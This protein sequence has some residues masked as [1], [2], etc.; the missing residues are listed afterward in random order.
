MAKGKILAI[1]DERYFRGFYRVLLE[2][3]GYHIVTADSGKG[4]LEYLYREEFDLVILD[5]ELEG[6]NVLEIVD[7]VKCLNPE[8]EILAVTG[9]NDVGLAVRA[10]KK[11]TSEYLLKPI[12]PEAFLLLLGKILFRQSVRREH[13]KLLDENIDYFYMVASL[14]KC[15]ELLKINDIDR[16]SDHIADLMMEMLRADGACLWLYREMARHFR[17][18]SVRGLAKVPAEEMVFPLG[19]GERKKFLDGG[20]F[21]AEARTVMVPIN[22]AG[23]TIAL[24]RIEEPSGRERFSRKDFKLAEMVAEFA[25]CGLHNALLLRSLE[26]NVLRAPSGEFYNMA[27]FRDHVSKEIL[28]S[29]RYR[30]NLSILKLKIENYQDLMGNFSDKE[31]EET[32]R[33]MADAVNT[34]LREADIMAMDQPDEYFI[35]LP[36]TDFW[37]ALLTQRRILRLLRPS[38][39]SPVQVGKICTPLVRV[40]AATFPS[41]GATFHQLSEVAEHRLRQIENSLPVRIGIEDVPFWTAMEHVLC[42]AG[43]DKIMASMPEAGGESC[44]FPV[45]GETIETTMRS[46]CLELVESKR[47]RGFIYRGCDGFAS[48]LEGFSLVEGIEKSATSVYLLGGNR[49]EEWDYQRIIPLHISDP[50]FARFPFFFYLSEEFAYAL[51]THRQDENGEWL[52]FHSSDFYFVENMILKLQEQ[53]RLQEQM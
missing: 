28:K 42:A 35:L 17:L 38:A 3:E 26:Q 34:T 22:Y 43:R 7:A 9:R 13:G 37:G 1:D 10:M 11:G 4:G 32:L 33:R 30:R 46:F 19:E 49:R 25:A 16:L 45:T 31:V 47:A 6:E 44:F 40:R 18:R 24:L 2:K 8:Q 51:I 14:R 29:R 39:G 48:V 53:Y 36:E 50:G 41:D 12:D 21:D 23:E 52:G 15:L 20:A 5:M 27:F